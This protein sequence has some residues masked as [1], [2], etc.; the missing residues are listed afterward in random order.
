LSPYSG[1]HHS[2]FGTAPPE[3]TEVKAVPVADFAALGSECKQIV[4]QGA[5]WLHID[6]MVSQA[7]AARFLFCSKALPVAAVSFN[8]T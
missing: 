2:S 3:L 6:V 1:S 4:Q 5:D 8:S 7:P